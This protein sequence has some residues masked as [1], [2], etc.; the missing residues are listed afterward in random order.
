MADRSPATEPDWERLK[1]YCED[2][3]R[4]LAVVYEALAD[5]GRIV[6]ADEPAR[7]ANE[8]TQR[9]LSDW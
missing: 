8:T 7:D 3:V 5:G 4:A 9:S 1:A 2:D 6:S